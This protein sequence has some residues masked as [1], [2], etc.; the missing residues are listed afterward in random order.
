MSHRRAALPVLLALLLALPAA[1]AAAPSTPSAADAVMLQAAD[2]RAAGL[3]VG[4]ERE[5][6]QESGD[7][8]WLCDGEGDTDVEGPKPRRTYVASTQA[9]AKGRESVVEQDISL[10]R[11]A[12]AAQA[13]F[14]KIATLA[15]SCTG[16]VTHLDDAPVPVTRTNGTLKT[17]VGGSPMIWVAQEVTDG[18]REFEYSVFALVGSAIQTIELEHQGAQAKPIGAT[19]RTRADRLAA[20]LAKRWLA[21]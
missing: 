3:P 5:F 16:T 4:G 21:G 18:A 19:E 9:E 17:A 10:Y 7:R 13:A 8:P 20:T 12:A 11:S 14:A 2:S 1:A 6:A 15:Q